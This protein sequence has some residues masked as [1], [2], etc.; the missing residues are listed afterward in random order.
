[1]IIGSTMD[2][3]DG[4]YLIC[5]LESIQGLNLRLG[6]VSSKRGGTVCSNGFYADI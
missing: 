1:M 2:N 6:D 4:T 3:L 5:M